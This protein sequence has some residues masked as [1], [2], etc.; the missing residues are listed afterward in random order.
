[1]P[2]AYESEIWLT[3]SRLTSSR[4]PMLD[5]CTLGTS[6]ADSRKVDGLV[7]ARAAATWRGWMTRLSSRSLW[8]ARREG[9]RRGHAI[10]LNASL[11]R[12]GWMQQTF[13]RLPRYMWPSYAPAKDRQP[14]DG[15][16]DKGVRACPKAGMPPA[17]E[18][19]ETWKQGK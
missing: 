2:S 17:G 7:T 10:G 8:A 5:H 6:M 18:Y 13:C 14:P 3:S 16:I 12:V 4:P 15:S 1:M 19:N 11:L 9:V